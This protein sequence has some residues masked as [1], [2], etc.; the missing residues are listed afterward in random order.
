MKIMKLTGA[1][2]AFA[3]SGAA[4]AGPQWTYIQAGYLNADSAE[5][6]S[7]GGDAQ[8]WQ[9]EG[10]LGFADT[11]HVG[12]Q[13]F[14]ADDDLAQ[15]DVTAY[16]IWIGGNPHLTDSTDLV[17]ELAYMDGEFEEQMAPNTKSDFDAFG[18]RVG[19]R[20]MVTEKW[21]AN[22]IL[23]WWNGSIDDQGSPDIDFNDWGLQAGFRYMFNE[24]ISAGLTLTVNDPLFGLQDS[25]LIDIRWGF[26]NVL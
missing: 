26:G 18:A 17:F 23:Q 10:S 4:V 11:W 15:E 8:G 25:A 20:S 14:D 12:I 5:Q 2:A 19:T 21:E 6:G 16:E 13:Y 7:T 9:V 1:L 3:L 24:A 22:L